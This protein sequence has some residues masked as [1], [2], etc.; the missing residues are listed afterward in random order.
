M[1]PFRKAFL[2][3]KAA[4]LASCQGR[5]RC[6]DAQELLRGRETPAV[7]ADKVTQGL[8][9]AVKSRVK[10]Q[11]HHNGVKLSFPKQ[12]CHYIGGHDRCD[13]FWGLERSLCSA[14]LAGL[15]FL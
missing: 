10:S 11:S 4:T 12:S 5:R 13:S 6:Y 3:P 15:K 8:P 9:E 14:S 1:K 2:R 7:L